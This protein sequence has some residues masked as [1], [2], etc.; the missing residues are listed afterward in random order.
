M[1]LLICLVI[2]TIVA[3]PAITAYTRKTGVHDA[4]PVIID[5]VIGQWLPLLLLPPFS[6][7]AV[8]LIGYGLAFVL[9]RLFDILKPGPIRRV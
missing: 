8:S 5:E 4:G 9:F 6:M 7:D 3:F 2:I 1:G